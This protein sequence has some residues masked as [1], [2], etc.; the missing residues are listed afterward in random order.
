M[1]TVRRL[2]RAPLYSFGVILSV[3]LLVLVNGSALG[4]LWALGWQPLPYAQPERLV[5]LRI[6]LKDIDFQ[7]GLSPSLLDAVRARSETFAGAIGAAPVKAALDPGGRVWHTQR[8]SADFH[9]VLGV[10]PALGRALDGAEDGGPALLLSHA[11]W[12]AQFDA[13]AEVIG[14]TWRIGEVDYRIVGVMPAGFAWPDTRVQAWTAFAATAEERA[15]DAAGGFGQFEVAARLAPGVTLAQA[16]GALAAVLANSGSEFLRNPEGPARAD[17]RPWRAQFSAGHFQ[18]LLLV[19]ASALLLLLIAA[20]NLAGLALDRMLARR[21]DHAVLRAL[22]AVP[23]QLRAQAAIELALPAA[24]GAIVGA[25]LV[26]AGIA[27]LR[28]RGLLPEALPVASATG[29]VAAAMGA[30]AGALA[31]LLALA[32]LRLG[33]GRLAAGALGSRA[34]SGLSPAQGWLLVAQLALTVALAGGSALLLRSAWNLAAENRGFDAANVVLTQVDLG[35]QV[36]EAQVQA[37]RDAVAALPG[38]DG[39]ARADMPP[40]GG[41]EFMTE[42]RSAVDPEPAEARI[43]SV[44]PG[45]FDVLRIPLVAGRAFTPA[46]GDAAVVVDEVYARRFGQPADAL[47]QILRQ[48]DD[49]DATPLRIVGV[50]AAVKQKSLDEELRYGTLYQPIGGSDPVQF[51]VS[52]GVDAA[53]VE[54]VRR[55]LAQVAPDAELLVNVA[56]DQAVARTQQVRVALME[57]VSLFALATL[58]LSALGVYAALSTA[59]RRRVAEFGVR[60]AIGA[61]PGA[62]LCEVYA[63]SAWILLPGLLLGLGLGLALARVAGDRLHRVTPADASS[64]AVALATVAIIGALAVLPSAF[65]AMRVAPAAALLSR[66]DRD[67]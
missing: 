60:M 52:R 41:A 58:L 53:P 21:R 16:Q 43:A 45:Y 55:L 25:L 29:V 33:Q 6:D 39:V 48:A 15:T 23:R 57:A 37:L 13:S 8:I 38:M 36:S 65:R 51:L 19:Q 46:D 66:G 1:T 63:R 18:P 62:I 61:A 34:V 14:Q 67:A 28:A 47:G 50:A 31:L 26:P 20:T 24:I 27:L 12:R 7:V 30:A 3:A 4:G 42:L 10:A 64:W 32:L 40:F 35:D 44:S 9:Q 17:V 49:A 5:Q 22:G 54:A 59:V 2:L 56:L 11:T